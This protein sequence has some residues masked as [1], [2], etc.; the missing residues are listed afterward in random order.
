MLPA[1]RSEFRKLFTIRSTYILSGIAMLLVV[2]LGFW[3]LG[4]KS[5]ASDPTLYME[6]AKM[7]G[8]VIS[9]FVA[10]IGILL[11]THEYRYNTIMYTLTATG[12]RSK[13]L[14]AKLL[15]FGVFT[16]V[17]TLLMMLLAAF[18]A[19]IGVQL[20]HDAVVAQ[21]FF[22]GD[23]LWRTVSYGL[24]YS[25]AALLFGLLFRHVV[26][27]MAVFFIVP[28]TVEG[29]LGLLLKDNAKYLPFTALEQINAA[30]LF[31]PLQAL[32]IFGAYLLGGWII[33]WILF[34]KRD[35]N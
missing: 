8:N 13:V 20:A 26:G 35:A 19:W 3:A 17:F 27:A 33:A 25:M 23:T 9:L 7:G 4:Y 15:V 32:L 29:L 28:T 22:Y 34:L 10:I 5:S 31:K 24:L 30:S 11:I 6:A 21:Q 12:S 1:I 14:A 2:I 16:I 18:C